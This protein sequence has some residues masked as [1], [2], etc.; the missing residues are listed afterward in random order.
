MT[1]AEHLVFCKKCVNR[2]FNITEGVLCTLTGAK[3]DFEDN[4]PNYQLDQ[5]TV[6]KSLPTK[7]LKPNKKRATLAIQMIWAVL[8]VDLFMIISNYFQ[9]RLLQDFNDGLYV[10]D[11]AIS[12]NDLRVGLLSLVYV[13]IYI[14]SVVTFIR[15]FRRAY[16]NLAARTSIDHGEGWAAGGWFVPI[17]SLFRPYT[18]MK[19]LFQKTDRIIANKTGSETKNNHLTL[20]GFW[21]ALWLIVG[22]IGNYSLKTMFKEDTIETL[23]KSTL[24]DIATSIGEIPIGILAILIISAFIK[25]ESQLLQLEEE[26]RK[27]LETKADSPTIL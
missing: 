25:K 20:I 23:S 22:Y 18:I 6:I 11:E 1:R 26:D 27:S 10:T 4:C 9:Y 15:W 14:I 16:N 7:T 3:A 2:D 8:I 5:N 13:L 12:S 17:I 21:W 19:E 24:A